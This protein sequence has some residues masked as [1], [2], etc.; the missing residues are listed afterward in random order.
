MKQLAIALGYVYVAHGA[1]EY[2]TTNP[3]SQVTG[4][5]ERAAQNMARVYRQAGFVL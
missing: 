1:L 4:W 2:V 5:W 3:H